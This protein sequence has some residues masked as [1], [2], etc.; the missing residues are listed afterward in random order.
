MQ[1]NTPK[2]LTKARGILFATTALSIAVTSS[3]YGAEGWVST[4]TKAFLPLINSSAVSQPTT[5]LTANT[6][7]AVAK[8]I[9]STKAIHVTVG[10]ALRNEAQLD[11][12]IS[13]IQSGAARQFL[14]PD[15]FKELY[16][17]TQQQVDLVVK[18]LT[19]AGFTNIKVAP[20]RLFVT[21]NGTA[22]TV[23]TG[24]NTT[25]KGF[26]A[27][28]GRNVY[29]NSTDAQVPQSLSGV[30]QT[31]LGLQNVVTAHTFH[32]SLPVP[33]TSTVAGGLS[34]AAAATTP[35][36]TGHNPTEFPAIYH[37]GTTP[38]ATNVSVGIIT[39]GDLTQTLSDLKTFTTKNTLTAVTTSVVKTG[40]DPFNDTYS[41]GDPT[42]W[43]LDSQSIIGAS[44]GVKSLIFYTAPDD[45]TT[46]LAF[47]DALTGAFNAAVTDINTDKT[48]KALIVNVSL[49]WCESDAD[50]SSVQTANDNI[51]KQA[52]A[53]GQ[54]FSI[55]SG[56]AGAY[57]CS[58]T[59]TGYPGKPYTN[60]YTVSAPTNSPYVISVGGTALFTNAGAYSSEKVWNEG[61]AAASSTDSTK[62]LW[63]TGGG[64]SKSETAPTWQKTIIG[65]STFRGIPDIAFDAAQ[66]SGAI[67]YINGSTTQVINGVTYKNQ[68]GGTSLASPIFAGLYAR[69]QSDNKNALG[70]PASTFYK[71]FTDTTV[72]SP[73]VHDVTSGNNGYGT[74]YTG[75]SAKAGWD[76]VT[77]FGSIDISNLNAYIKAK[78]VTP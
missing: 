8:D 13:F 25:L 76:A 77:G 24:F 44:G 52:V 26:K 5:G 41:S 4:K 42:E 16:S 69:L 14:T 31:V 33:V 30:V 53:Q 32:K 36:E 48:P 67:L 75:Y 49:G 17:P 1:L 22:G 59:P 18:H 74:T 12:D 7:A 71:Y 70:F 73:L 60:H 39:W 37:V 27:A 57:Q 29:A 11:K 62:R 21:A 45:A 61:T 72:T 23:H 64:Y 28:D 40:T 20:N 66:T 43:N 3:V 78:A 50:A 38:A 19:K 9:A 65:T 56:D 35:V 58:T 68:V 2:S 51:F 15:K 54:T 47:F 34:N 10:L 55:S 46:N 6:A 63:A